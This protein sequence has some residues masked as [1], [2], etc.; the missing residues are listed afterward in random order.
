MSRKMHLTKTQLAI[1]LLST[2]IAT[3][4]NMVLSQQ[5]TTPQ[6]PVIELIEKAPQS[7]QASESLVEKQSESS[8]TSSDDPR[9]KLLASSSRIGFGASATGGSKYVYVKSFD[10]LKSALEQTGNYVLLDPALAG[11][12]VV[13]T[14]TV[15]PADNTTLDGSLAPGHSLVADPNMQGSIAMLNAIGGSKQGNQIFHSIKMD[16][17]YSQH[18]VTQGAIQISH[19]QN[20]WINHIEVTDFQDDSILLGFD[21]ANSGNYITVSNSKFHNTGKGPYMFYQ[22]QLNHGQG[23][24]TMFFND[25]A[26]NERNPNNRGAQ[27]AHVFN[28]YIH[29]W[30]WEGVVSGGKGITSYPWLAG[31]RT[32]D[33]NMLS[34]SNYYEN[35]NP[36]SSNNCAEA[37]DPAVGVPYGGWMYTDGQSIY[38]GSL[39]TCGSPRHLHQSSTNGPGAPNIPYSYKL[40]PASQV[41]AYVQKNAG[42]LK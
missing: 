28:N 15:Y 2:L 5:L 18:N 37:A 31:N 16:G 32:V 27:H 30:R 1:F 38:D 22:D 25:I 42:T 7:E 10:E 41:K 36:L 33:S 35:T 12:N 6:K 21:Q 8:S 23:H 11:K 24:V 17:K 3:G 26:A 9:T 40:M 13:F 14:H 4:S 34:Q 19:G 39:Q 20:Y 29:D